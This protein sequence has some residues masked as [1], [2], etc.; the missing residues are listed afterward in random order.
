MPLHPHVAHQP[1]DGHTTL[2][3]SHCYPTAGPLHGLL[4]GLSDSN[5]DPNNDLP[6]LFNN[7]VSLPPSLSSPHDVPLP[8][9]LPSHCYR[10]GGPYLFFPIHSYQLY[11]YLTFLLQ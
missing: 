6:S 1:T 11:A 10:T 3:P 7:D 4:G 8:N 9:L 5:N 2:T